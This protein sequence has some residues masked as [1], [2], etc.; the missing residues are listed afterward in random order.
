MK[1]FLI[2]PLLWCP[3]VSA[4]AAE[5][6]QAHRLAVQRDKW[7]KLWRIEKRINATRPERREWPLRAENIR[8]EEVREIQD[9]ARRVVP[10]AIVNISG[11]VVGCPCEEGWL[12][13][14]QAWIL[15]SK[16]DKTFGLQL[17]KVG[18]HWGIGLIQRW[19]LR[20]ENL[21]RRRASFASDDEYRSAQEALKE[22]FPH[23]SQDSQEDEGGKQ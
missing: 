8:D 12:C 11:V 4:S 18:G 19:W 9:V 6:S 5:T 10:D 14:D 15:A 1:A 20:Y 2:F 16:A 22:Q 13:S 21:Q 23:C 3:L 7:E 17:S